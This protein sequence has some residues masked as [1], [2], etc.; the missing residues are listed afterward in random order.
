MIPKDPETVEQV[1]LFQALEDL[2]KDGVEM[3]RGNRIEEGAVS[4]ILACATIGSWR[5]PSW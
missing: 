1:M 5:D 2:E 3:A 4:R